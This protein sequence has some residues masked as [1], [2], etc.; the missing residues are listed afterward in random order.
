MRDARM[1]NQ[2]RF[3]TISHSLTRP[4]S[5]S[6]LAPL[7]F[8]ISAEL[9]KVFARVS[10]TCCPCP[11]HSASAAFPRRSAIWP[12]SGVLRGGRRQRVRQWKKDFYAC[13]AHATF[14]EILSIRCLPSKRESDPLVV[15]RRLPELL[16]TPS[17]S[18]S[19]PS[20]ECRK[21]SL[22]PLAP[23]IRSTKT[24][25][26]KGTFLL[27]LSLRRQMKHLKV[28]REGNDGA[29]SWGVFDLREAMRLRAGASTRVRPSPP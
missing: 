2:L 14:F 29:F 5:S 6:S 16:P 11:P 13:L 19:S 22:P 10:M 4:A 23:S 12:L 1:A 18:P 9:I 3:L 25:T 24:L 28:E 26:A 15:L 27:P 17:L 20:P 8:L 21:S 7:A